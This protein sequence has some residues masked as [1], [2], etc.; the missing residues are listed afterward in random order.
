[1]TWSKNEAL[2]QYDNSGCSE[3]VVQSSGSSNYGEFT[4]RVL[5]WFACDF[6][7]E[8]IME[9][10]LE[11]LWQPGAPGSTALKLASVADHA[12]TRGSGGMARP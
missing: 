6:R 2:Y 7:D 10:E 5:A 12:S 8:L 3:S 11:I 9:S 4:V 1:M